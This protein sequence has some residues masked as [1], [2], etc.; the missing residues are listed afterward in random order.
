MLKFIFWSL[1]CINGLLFAY[2]KGYLGNFRGN[3]HEPAR[4]KNEINADKL[5]LMSSASADVAVARAQKVKVEADAPKADLIACL[6]I[7][8]FSDIEAKRVE[9]L[10]APL[11][12]GDRLHRD[13]VNVATAEATTHIVFIPPQGSKEGAD[14]KAGELKN[15]GVTN[16]FIISDNTALKWGISLGVFKSE[17][18]AKT[19]LAALNK[20]GVVS[21]RIMTRGPGANKL[22]FQ[23]KDIDSAAKAK[24]DAIVAKYPNAEASSCKAP[25]A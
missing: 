1:L 21:A 15:L 25:S 10:L 4:L 24:I 18:A 22:I 7:G 14:K 12:L 20:Q 8:K 17:N 11:E 19:L 3:E 5:T 2:G 13:S 16:Y 6:E 9:K 23:L